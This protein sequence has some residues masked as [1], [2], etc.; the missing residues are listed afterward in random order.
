MDVTN[1]VYTASDPPAMV[2]YVPAHASDVNA[3]NSNSAIAIVLLAPTRGDQH[4][5]I[6]STRVIPHNLEYR[7]ASADRW[8]FD[9]DDL[10]DP[11]LNGGGAVAETARDV[12][13]STT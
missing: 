3:A 10:P 12:L 9:L 6:A 7:T 2:E 8:N 5:L 11:E 13:R 1:Q 4:A